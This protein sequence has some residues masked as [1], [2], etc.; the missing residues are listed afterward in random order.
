MVLWKAI[1]I[2]WTWL[3]PDF[4]RTSVNT[5]CKYLLLKYCFEELKVIRVQFSVSGQNLRSQRAVERIG[6]KKEGV[7]RNHRI[8]SDGS[9]HDNVFYSIIDSEWP[10]VKENLHYLLANKYS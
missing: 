9:I 4:W 3:S 1:E 5:E 2:G 6:A 7:F 10:N 8:K